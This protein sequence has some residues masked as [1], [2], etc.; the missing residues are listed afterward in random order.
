M[1]EAADIEIGAG[2]DVDDLFLHLAL[3]MGIVAPD[4]TFLSVNMTLAAILGIGEQEAVGSS[5]RLL[6]GDDLDMAIAG[7]PDEPWPIAGELVADREIIR[8]DGESRWVEIRSS[9][10]HDLTGRRIALV[11]L[12]T[13]VSRHVEAH[14]RVAAAQTQLRLLLE[15][16]GD[17]VMVL[18]D[19]GRVKY[20]SPSE[21]RILGYPREQRIGRRALEIVHPDDAAQVRAT[22]ERVAQSSHQPYPLRC[23]LRH[24]DGS[25]RRVEGTVANHF[26]EPSLQGL[27]LSLRDV[28]TIHQTEAVHLERERRYRQLVDDSPHA[29][30]IDVDWQ[31][32]F[33]NRAAAELLG[34][35][36]PDELV[37]RQLL[38]LVHPDARG[39]L[40][41][42]R[43]RAQGA[44][45]TVQTETRLVRF[46]GSEVEIATVARPL[47]FTG[48][49]ATYTL[50][51]DITDQKRN[52][53][54][55]AYQAAH[56]QL[57]GLPNR[58][59]LFDRIDQSVARRAREGSETAVMVVD[60]DHFKRINDEFGHS[61]GDEILREA[62]TR[63]MGVVRPTDTVARLGGDEFTI[64]CE[65]ANPQEAGLIA[66]RIVSELGRSASRMGLTVPLGASVGVAVSSEGRLTPRALLRAADSAMY[67]AKQAGRGQWRM[68]DGATPDTP[69]SP[70]L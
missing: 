47:R 32:I 2:V 29:I 42:A 16:T 44:S 64:V 56:D 45:D 13:D 57:T 67:E 48:R 20:S 62:A 5:A 24:L 3:G 31:V 10:I 18:D 33:A 55:L 51:W 8:D 40:I 52:E 6:F 69:L 54:Q 35:A 61:V 26:D 60:L 50:A 39:L 68:A 22:L 11:C 37:G 53:E 70:P 36:H 21:E 28:S 19:G 46:D 1:D 63:L 34:A 49:D 59:L 4:G 38:D 9:P 14:H 25:Y 27:V 7:E 12:V 30:L 15:Q 58:W 43:Q 17:L 41:D 66:A 23:R 65:V